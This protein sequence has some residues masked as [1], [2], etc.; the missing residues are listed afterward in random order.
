MREQD[1]LDLL[2]AARFQP[3]GRTRGVDEQSAVTGEKGITRGEARRAEDAGK[4]LGPGID[5]LCG[6]TGSIGQPGGASQEKQTRQ[7]GHRATFHDTISLGAQGSDR[8]VA[9][10]ARHAVEVSVEAGEVGKPMCLY[11]RDD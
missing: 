8:G 11:D 5:G 9:G 4:H 2:D 7:E 1:G 10:N 6:A 3:V